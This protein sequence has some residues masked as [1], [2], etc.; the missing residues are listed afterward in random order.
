[1]ADLARP[2]RVSNVVP[3]GKADIL[4]VSADVRK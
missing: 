4:Q 1:M 3:G 2:A